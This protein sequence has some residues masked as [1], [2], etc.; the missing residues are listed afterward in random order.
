MLLS[1]KTQTSDQAEAEF[2][3]RLERVTQA[4]DRYH[5]YLVRLTYRYTRQWQDAE[6]IVSDLW[7]YC[8][9]HVPLE[10]IGQLPLLRRK[11]YLLFLDHYRRQKSRE[12]VV[13][14]VEDM[15]AAIAP[16]TSPASEQE[17]ARFEA[18]FWAELPGIELTEPQRKAAWLSLRYGYTFQEIAERIGKPVSTVGDWVALSKAAI[19]TYLNNAESTLS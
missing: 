1:A 14:N 11:A 7:R 3:L 4:V 12:T 16:P 13:E 5:E 8:L 19:V 15:P 6:N 10:K 17:E 9:K 18:K 2:D